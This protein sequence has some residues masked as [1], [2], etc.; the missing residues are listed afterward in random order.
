MGLGCA[1]MMAL[2]TVG[3]ISLKWQGSGFVVYF[4]R[5]IVCDVFGS[6]D[7]ERLG[8][9]EVYLQYLR[10]CFHVLLL[11]RLSVLTIIAHSN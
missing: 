9:R 6:M 11:R 10:L 1:G 3:M 4:L 2:F 5:R 7:E 8:M